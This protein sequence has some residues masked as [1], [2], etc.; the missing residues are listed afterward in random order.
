MPLTA[1]NPLGDAMA[2]L[3][4]CEVRAA[5]ETLLEAVRRWERAHTR[6]AGGLRAVRCWGRVVDAC[7][8]LAGVLAG[9]GR[10]GCPWGW[11]VIGL[12]PEDLAGRLSVERLVLVGVAVALASLCERAGSGE[13]VPPRE[14]ERVAQKLRRAAAGCERRS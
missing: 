8:Y 12:G 6:G 11:S 4:A 2:D 7:L 9:A 10:N 13:M 1:T 14:W 3:L 5:S